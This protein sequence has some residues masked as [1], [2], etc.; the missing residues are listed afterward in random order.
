MFVVLNPSTADEV[1]DDPTIRRCI[2]FA[3]AWGYGALCMT[4]L[5][6]FRATDPDDMKAAAEPIGPQ[7]DFHLQRLARGGWRCR[8]R[9]G[10]YGTHLERNAAVRSM[11]PALH[12]LRKTADGHPGH[13]L[14]LPKILTPTP[15]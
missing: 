15:L 7:N 14:Y 8:G 5:F 4:N 12:Y 3:K 2:A 10:V 13:P 1:T 6:A 9:M 11:V